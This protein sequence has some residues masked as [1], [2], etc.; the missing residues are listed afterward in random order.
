MM[1]HSLR[2]LLAV[3]LTS[4]ALPAFAQ[5]NFSSSSSTLVDAPEPMAPAPVA[6]S[7]RGGGALS[8]GTLPVRPFS[9]IGFSVKA[10]V[11]GV[12]FD[13]A[14]PLSRKFN[15]RGG[16]T[17][18]DYK[19]NT[20]SDGVN[21]AGTLELGNAGVGIDWF[22]WAGAFHISPG[23][24]LYNR[25]NATATANVPAGGTFTLNDQQYTSSQTDPIH[26][27]M[28]LHMSH[29]AA[30]SLTVGWGNMIPR[31][32]GHW[33][34]PVEVGVMAT[35]RPA[36]TLSLAGSACQQGVCQP[37]M[38]DPET[39]KDLAAEQ[40]SLNN[41]LAPLRFYPIVSV[42]FSYSFGHTAPKVR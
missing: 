15:L 25:N 32:G 9:A 10:G 4:A 37:V 8:A 28:L 36:L 38:T 2:F 27:S 16:A 40:V 14:T 6:R 30:P 35:N 41:S 11:G 39:Q 26:G 5:S 12:G 42:G 21:Y 18:F 34:V 20:S 13:V 31:A 22:P 23:V 3:S 24:V 33:S 19:M 17:Y 7:S 1:K 29:K